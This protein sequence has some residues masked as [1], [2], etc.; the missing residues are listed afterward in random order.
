MLP[1]ALTGAGCC[2]A[3][4]QPARR[5]LAG[6][7]TTSVSCGKQSLLPVESLHSTTSPGK[8]TKEALL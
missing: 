7:R 6:S 5:D 3:A 2:S 8:V 4:A 1:G